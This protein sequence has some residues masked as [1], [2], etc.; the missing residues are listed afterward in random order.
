M[1]MDQGKSEALMQTPV[2]APEEIRIDVEAARRAMRAALAATTAI[3]LIATVVLLP[4]TP[5]MT[6]TNTPVPPTPCRRSAP[7]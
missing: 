1:K 5:I 3:A 4:P 7:S 2:S 6:P